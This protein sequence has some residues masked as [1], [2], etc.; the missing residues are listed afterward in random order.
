MWQTQRYFECMC[1]IELDYFDCAFIALHDECEQYKRSARTAINLKL[2][3]IVL[4]NYLLSHDTG[5]AAPSFS[6]S[7]YTEAPIAMNLFVHARYP[8][9]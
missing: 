1:N 3:K 8:T 5:Y 7:P 2:F 4:H 9:F 6:G